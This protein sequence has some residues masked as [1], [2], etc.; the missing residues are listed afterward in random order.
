MEESGVF[1][2]GQHLAVSDVKVDNSEEP[3]RVSLRIKQSKTD[4]SAGNVHPS[5]QDRPASVPRGITARLPGG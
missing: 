3:E 5:P 4:L 1:D 2:P